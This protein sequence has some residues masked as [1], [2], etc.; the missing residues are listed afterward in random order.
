ME[1]VDEFFDGIRPHEAAYRRSTFPY[2][3]VKKGDDFVVVKC[4]LILTAEPTATPLTQFRSENVRAGQYSLLDLKAEPR[5]L[6]DQVVSGKIRTPDGEL[7]F[8]TENRTTTVALFHP[9]WLERQRRTSVLTVTAGNTSD[10]LKQ[11]SQDWE[12]KASATPYD[13]LHELLAEYDLGGLRNEVTFEAIALAVAMVDAR[14]HVKGGEAIVTIRVAEGLTREKVSLGYRVLDRLRCVN[15]DIIRGHDLQW[16]SDG[17]MQ[18]AQTEFGVPI[19]AVVHCIISYDGI[20]QHHYYI[21]DPSKSQNRRRAAYEEFDP[22]LETLRSILLKVGTG[23]GRD[24]RSFESGV[25]CLLWMLG[26]SP[27][28]VGEAGRLGAPDLIAATPSGHLVVVECTTGVLKAESKMTLVVERTE[29]IRK[30]L[31]GTPFRTLA[32]MVTSRPADEI[33]AD[34]E[35]AEKLGVLV[36]NGDGLKEGLEL[37]TLMPPNADALYEEAEKVVR[38]AQAKHQA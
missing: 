1:A 23:K 37:R 16:T 28:H 29:R 21:H 5:E 35:S 7:I 26:F 13:G 2:L 11:P 25:A 30:R 31:V 3:A 36:V 18:V 33:R 10:Y 24:Q 14:S 9:F 19:A 6:I 32:A 4:A 8:P 15:R 27:V 12:V 38:N 17:G 20:V 22:D 34:I